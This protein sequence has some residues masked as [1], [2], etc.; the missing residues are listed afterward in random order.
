M[1][2]LAHAQKCAELSPNLAINKER[3]VAEKLANKSQ[4]KC[5]ST[6]LQE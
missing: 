6:L 1:G 2:S 5:K 4:K 3:C